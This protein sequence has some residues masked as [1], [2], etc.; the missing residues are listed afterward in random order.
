MLKRSQ[1]RTK[2][3][4]L[5]DELMSSTPASAPGFCAT[6]PTGR[7]ASRAKPTMMLRA[8]CA[9][10]RRR[11]RYPR[12]TDDCRH[13]VGA[14]GVIG[15]DGVQRVVGAAAGVGADLDG[16]IIQIVRRDEAEQRTHLAQAFR[17]VGAAKCAT[18][19]VALWIIAPPRSSKPTSSCVTVL[20]TFGPVTNM[21]LVPST[22]KMKSVM[23]GE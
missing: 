19:L 10:P 16:R 17:L 23:A 12:R 3:A 22:M 11:R 14:V 18:P 4:P 6:I 7:P 13:V 21:W 15:D 9:A 5:S 2:R 8:N 1:K 20:S